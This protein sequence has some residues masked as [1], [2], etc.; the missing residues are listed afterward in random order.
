[1]TT[2]K[3]TKNRK[4]KRMQTMVRSRIKKRVAEH[5][6]KVKKEARK[7]A[8]LG[9]RTGPKKS[10]TLHV[11]NL[12]P[13]KLRLI[14]NIKN[15]RMSDSR[16]KTLEKMALKSKSTLNMSVVK[17]DPVKREKQYM[18]KMENQNAKGTIFFFGD[19]FPRFFSSFLHIAI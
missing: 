10:K 7:L 1:M 5:K 14:D 9:I 12:Y 19:D 4:S 6:R 8:A 3:S 2:K 16:K 15:Q 13:Y 11:P 18:D 17:E